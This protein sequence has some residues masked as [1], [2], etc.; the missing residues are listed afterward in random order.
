MEPF[1][2][3]ISPAVVETL[4]LHL[5][6]HLDGFDAE[7]FKHPI[8][9]M[10]P[11]L[12][13]K[14]RTQLIADG[15][16]QVLPADFTHRNQILSAMLHPD[17]IDHTDLPSDD[18][19]MCGWGLW[20][21]TMV[22]G[23]HGLDDFEGS[24]FLLKEMTKRGTSEFD[25]RPYLDAD[26]A[27]ALEIITPWA[28]DENIHVRRLASEG[29]RPRLPWG[30]QLKQLVADPSPILPILFEM[31]DDDEL[32][33]RRSVANNLN[34][35]AKDHPDM[36]AELANEWMKGASVPREK[37]IRHACRTLIKQG[38]SEAMRAFGVVEAQ[39]DA[40]VIEIATPEVTF[41]E[42]L[43]FSMILRSTSQATQKIVIDYVIHFQKANGRL[44]PK[45]FKWKKFDLKRGERLVL[46]RSHAIRH[47][48]TRKYYMGD[49]ALSLRIN[50]TEY[51]MEHFDLVE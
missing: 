8:L 43:D 42:H 1:K 15:L 7:A 25:I 23:Q 26:Q 51:G 30:M 13:L 34:D 28:H 37:L 10:L 9:E 50:G 35:I 38:H 4:A 21:L 49:Q 31:R 17:P 20:P 39:I 33:V 18:D 48:T 41:G 16:H 27:R 5:A 14:Q 36:V 32:Y 44:S 29:T 40:P 2:N 6:R 46:K 3:K 11:S 24:L 22:V 19:G 45:V 12:E 47:I